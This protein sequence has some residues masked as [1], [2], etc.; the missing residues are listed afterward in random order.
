M[1]LRP[2][3]GASSNTFLSLLR[4]LHQLFLLYW[5][6]PRIKVVRHGVARAGV[7]SRI[8]DSAS[9]GVFDNLRLWYRN[10]DWLTVGRSAHQLNMNFS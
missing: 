4:N 1:A 9:M 10:F 2:K 8:N 6:T 5:M 3:G 7:E